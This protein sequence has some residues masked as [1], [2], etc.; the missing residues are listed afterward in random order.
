MKWSFR[1]QRDCKPQFE[2]HYSRASGHS[3]G[4]FL[5]VLKADIV[6]LTMHSEPF[7]AELALPLFIQ[8][9]LGIY[10]NGN[11]LNLIIIKGRKIHTI[12]QRGVYV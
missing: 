2:N 1:P 8:D 4:L 5:W 10:L 9:T 7:Q 6:C 3:L 12:V 11:L